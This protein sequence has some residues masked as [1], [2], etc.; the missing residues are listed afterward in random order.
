MI[1]IVEPGALVA[2]LPGALGFVPEDSLCAVAL[3]GGDMLCVLR[4]DRV[5]AAESFDQIAKM[6]AS[7]GADAMIAVWVVDENEFWCRMCVDE[8]DELTADFGLAL[9]KS[10]VRLQSTLVTDNKSW[11]RCGGGERGVVP[12][13][14]ALTVAAVVAGRPQFA[15]RAEMAAVF[16]P[17]GEV[18]TVEQVTDGD[19]EVEVLGRS[20][21]DGAVRDG[22]YGAALT[23]EA[24]AVENR[25]LAAARVLPGEFR[26]HALATAA[27]LA[28]CRGDGAFAGEALDQSLA[29]GETSMARM[30]DTA[31]QAGFEPGKIRA[32]AGAKRG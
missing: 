23:D 27:F 28:Y 10:G 30:L 20:L 25:L 14:S 19:G 12:Q 3:K 18:L 26:A 6:A 5:H 22:F 2:A 13:S 29:A 1:K 8:R 17:A 21:L 9:L 32:L 16:D 31:L 11:Q 4:I 24:A 15:S 7:N